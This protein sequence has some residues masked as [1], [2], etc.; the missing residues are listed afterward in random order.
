MIFVILVAI[1]IA[2]IIFSLYFFKRLLNPLSVYSAIWLGLLVLY[3]I[4]LFN[5]YNLSVQTW[6]VIGGSFLSFILGITTISVTRTFHNYQENDCNCVNFSNIFID[7]GKAL[8]IS[9]IIFGLIGLFGALQH[10]EVLLNLYGTVPNIL[11]HLSKIYK[12][13]IAGEIEGVIPYLSVASYISI[14]LAGI[15]SAYKRRFTLISV[16]PFTA[17][18]LKGIANVGRQG[19]LYGFLEYFL[20]FF[21]FKSFLNFKAKEENKDF[22]KRRNYITVVSLVTLTLIFLFSAL[23]IKDFRGNDENY[24]GET[25]TI[26]VLKKGGIITPSL[27]LYVSGHVGVLNKFLFEES[28]S[29]RFGENTFQFIYNILAKIGFVERPNSYQKGYYIPMW[30][31]TGTYLRELYVDFGVLGVYVVPYLMGLLITFSWDRFF[32]WGSITDFV[33]VIHI[34]LIISFSFLMMITRAANWFLGIILIPVTLKL[35]SF[36]NVK[37]NIE[38]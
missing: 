17:F 29:A 11:I 18:I 25:R 35:I 1:F 8:K 30:T 13:R 14:F 37:R 26:N 27:Y 34:M 22:L 2:S 19:I 15:Y 36:V 7:K 21:I 16:L 23:F 10:W 12:M 4:K 24:I 38:V 5:Y 9:I 6:V 20:T 28:E 32:K 31:N 33:I 3:E